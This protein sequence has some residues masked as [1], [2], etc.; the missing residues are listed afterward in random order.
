MILSIITSTYVCFVFFFHLLLPSIYFYFLFFIFIFII[1]HH[2]RHYLL[3]FI[4][5]LLPLIMI[6][7]F[8]YLFIIIFLKEC[9]LASRLLLRGVLGLR[10]IDLSDEFRENVINTQ[11]QFRRNFEENAIELLS[12]SLPLLCGDDTG[13][14]EVALVAHKDDG[15]VLR[16]LHAEDLLAHVAEV[17][18]A[19]QG[20][21]GVHQDEAL[22]VLHVE[23]SHGGELLCARS[24]E[25]LEHALLA[26]DLALLPVRVLDR[27]VVLLDKDALHEENGDGRLAD[28]TTAENNKLVFLKRHCVSVIIILLLCEINVWVC[29]LCSSFFL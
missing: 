11:L 18:E 26:V 24:V 13:V 12:K 15:H 8:I 22:P 28:T 3:L 14:V 23:V 21:D 20:H 9:A 19:A 5:I 10:G 2:H 7:L 6:S 25:D 16:V 29:A 27:G 1:F 17:V 4:I